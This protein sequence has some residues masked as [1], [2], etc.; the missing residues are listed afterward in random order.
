MRAVAEPGTRGPLVLALDALEA[1]TVRR[2]AALA[3]CGTRTGL[4]FVF[5]ML[6]MSHYRQRAYMWGPDGVWQWD[7]FVRQLGESGTFSVF[8]VSSSQAW[9]EV[10]FHAAILT[11]TA[12]MIGFG[13][14]GVLLLHWA[15]VWSFGQRNPMLLDGG[16][17]LAHIVLLMLL[18]TQCFDGLR[19]FPP[20]VTATRLAQHWVSVL[21]HNIGVLAIGAQICLVYVVSGLYKVQGEMWQDGTALYYILRVPEFM[22]PGVSEH[23]FTNALLVTTMS[24]AATLM[25]VM[26]PVMILVDWLRG[27]ATVVMVAFHLSIALLMG[28]T[29]FALTMIAC[30]LV[31]LDQ[32]LRQAQ[33]LDLGRERARVWWGRALRPR[34]AS[35]GQETG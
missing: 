22:W 34:V 6:L 15:L 21:L 30:D 33:T 24:Y 31:F 20:L 8:A 11:S 13:G 14:R 1:M 29:G 18:L 16:D 23:V 12:V 28:L 19:L 7:V 17:N 3:V 35:G 5:L 4:G 25:L 27:P 10:V 32:W 26:F 9:F 2:L